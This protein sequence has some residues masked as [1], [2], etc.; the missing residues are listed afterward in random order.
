MEKMIQNIM[1]VNYD[2]DLEKTEPFLKLTPYEKRKQ[3]WD[4]FLIIFD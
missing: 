2:F 4:R 3:R 1:I